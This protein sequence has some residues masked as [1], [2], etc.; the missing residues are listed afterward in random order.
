MTLDGSEAK[1]VKGM[2]ASRNPRCSASFE[3]AGGNADGPP[4]LTSVQNCLDWYDARMHKEKH[5]ATN[6]VPAECL[7]ARTW[8]RANWT[9]VDH[10]HKG[11][12]CVT[13][14]Q[15]EDPALALMPYLAVVHV[16]CEWTSA[17][18]W[19]APA[20]LDFSRPADSH[21]PCRQSGAVLDDRRAKPKPKYQ[22]S[23]RK[24]FD[25]L[26]SLRV[27]WPGQPKPERPR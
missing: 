22:G 16:A 1:V 11:H 15:N 19:A 7:H 8:D 20:A 6:A 17:Q 5:K 3:A 13:V 2:L 10:N 14:T 4:T 21:Q 26:S 9:K 12:H 27:S 24:P 18:R 25:P 23:S